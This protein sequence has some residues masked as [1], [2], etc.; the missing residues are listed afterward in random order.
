MTC[1]RYSQSHISEMSCRPASAF[2]QVSIDRYRPTWLDQCWKGSADSHGEA[3]VLQ[4]EPKASHQDLES[5]ADAKVAQRKKNTLTLNSAETGEH[6]IFHIYVLCI[7]GMTRS[8]PFEG[9]IA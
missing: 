8:I 5:M 1:S 3:P 9:R 4:W 7:N 2:S 6:D